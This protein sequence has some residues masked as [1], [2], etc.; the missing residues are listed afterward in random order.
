MM[1]R[2]IN[3]WADVICPFCYLGSVWA[4]QAAREL[5]ADLRCRTGCGSGRGSG[6]GL[7]PR[8]GCC[9]HM[10]PLPRGTARRSVSPVGTGRG[11]GTSR[12]AAPA[13]MFGSMRTSDGPPDQHQMLEIVAA[14]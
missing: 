5:Q 8:S 1:N 9:G 3:I 13:A 14:D 7:G 10:F 12:E 2:V 4:K 6:S 11:G